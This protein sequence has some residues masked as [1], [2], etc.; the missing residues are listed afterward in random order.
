MPRDRI[1]RAFARLAEREGFVLRENQ[2]QLAHIL[3]DMMADGKSALVEAPTGLGKSLAAL[4]P[5]IAHGVD[6]KRT[7]IST[8]T[9]VLAEQYWQKDLPLALSLFD[10]S[11]E[12]ASRLKTAFIIG[13][14]RYVCLMAMDEIMDDGGRAFRSVAENGTEN[15]FRKI[16]MGSA[17]LWSSVSVPAACAGRGC[18]L[19]QDCY[20]YE[21]R[22]RAEKA[23]VVITNHNVLLQDALNGLGGD[24]DGFLGKLDYAIIDEAHDL[25]SSA[26]NALEFEL[27]PNKITSLQSLSTRLERELLSVASPNE[28]TWRQ[29]CE[30]YR[31]DMDSAK[32]ELMAY[33]LVNNRAGILAVS[34]SEVSEHPNVKQM[35]TPSIGVEK[36]TDLVVDASRLYSARTRQL[37]ESWEAPKLTQDTARNYLQVIEDAGLHADAMLSPNGVSV[38]YQ[39][40]TGN[41]PMLRVDTVGIAEP[42]RELLWDRLPT[43][44][45]SATLA[46]DGRFEFF[47]RTVGCDPDYEEILPSPFDYAKDAALYLPPA[48][49]IPDP[50]L[51]R[52]QGMEE[53]YFQ[54]VAREVSQ[55][56]EAMNGRTLALFHSRREMEAVYERL[57][58]REDLPVYIQG[59]S[60]AGAVGDR[61]RREPESS[62]LALRSYWTGFDA[63]GET[64][65]CV[66]I[67]RVPFEVPVEPPAVVRM[68]HLIGQGFD[69]FQAH[70]LAMAKMMVRQ[71]S[72][73]LIRR[74]GDKGIIALLDPRLR[75]KRY[76]EEILAN[77]P[78]DMRQFDDI[79]EAVA[80]TG[81]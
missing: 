27:S 41:D 69:P 47:R 62:L 29:V 77:L 17:R 6:G 50:S 4:I 60:G 1:E 56:I 45:L 28:T 71:G 11:E 67:V 70:T 55:I 14:Q 12:E 51:S 10:F 49:A 68:A 13:R 72:G 8:Y 26:Q 61:F 21:A 32:K 46:L 65:S 79:L 74:D 18:P 39:G 7:V 36:V 63:P 52:K 80:W 78:P 15:E 22:R 37:L 19:Y 5:A 33:G 44:C 64:L 43:A 81:V 16:A 23:H 35:E 34:P 42:L 25:Y 38:S 40:R 2:I 54:A 24:G 3:G 58:V 57:R 75:T 30:D 66:I 76:G 31:R 48:N 59:K 53:D 73:R 20:F 9:N